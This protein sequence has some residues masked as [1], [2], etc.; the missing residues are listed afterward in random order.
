MPDNVAVCLVP[1]AGDLPYMSVHVG[2]VDMWLTA[3]KREFAVYHDVQ[4]LPSSKRKDWGKV[5]TAAKW[6][7]TI[8][9]GAEQL[10]CT[11]FNDGDV[12]RPL[13]HA[14]LKYNHADS[15]NASFGVRMSKPVAK[16]LSGKLRKELE[17]FDRHVVKRGRTVFANKSG[18]V[19]KM[20]GDMCKYRF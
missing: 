6:S 11:D 19:L 7:F 9:S 12:L 3:P 20:E 16:R 14:V 4:T 13:D 1:Y 17:R 5:A 8:D 2:D 18:S 15:E 10:S